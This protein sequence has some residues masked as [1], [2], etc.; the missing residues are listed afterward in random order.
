[1]KP[2]ASGSLETEWE[3]IASELLGGGN[4]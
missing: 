3:R 4:A 1:L 2:A